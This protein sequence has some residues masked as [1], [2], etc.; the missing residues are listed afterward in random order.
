MPEP[1]NVDPT[2]RLC[3]HSV[4]LCGYARGCANSARI[5]RARTQGHVVRWGGG[6]GGMG[7]RPPPAGLLAFV[8]H[9]RPIQALLAATEVG[10]GLPTGCYPDG[11]VTHE[12]W[13]RCF[14]RLPVKR[15]HFEFRDLRYGRLVIDRCSSC[16]LSSIGPSGSELR[17]ALG[18]ALLYMVRSMPVCCTYFLGK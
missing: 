12:R 5:P 1:Y 2:L 14:A 15:R 4:R 11:P 7:W 3:R 13:R 6:E 18:A 8:G 10:L 9:R 16:F 17:V